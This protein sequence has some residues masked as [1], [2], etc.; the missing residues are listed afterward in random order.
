[1][2]ALAPTIVGRP[3]GSSAQSSAPPRVLAARARLAEDLVVPPENPVEDLGDLGGPDIFP[4]PLL[5]PGVV[6]G[7][8]L[9]QVGALLGQLRVKGSAIPLGRSSVTRPP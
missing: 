8:V 2:G 4:R 9:E 5:P 6:A 1:M 7:N 3:A